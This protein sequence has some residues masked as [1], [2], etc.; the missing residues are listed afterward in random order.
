MTAK[1]NPEKLINELNLNK[2]DVFKYL[3]TNTIKSFREKYN[4]TF[5]K[6][7]CIT[8]FWGGYKTPKDKRK[9]IAVEN[10]KKSSDT[11]EKLLKSKLNGS[12]GYELLDNVLKRIDYDEFLKDYN[13]PMSKKQLAI[14]Y[15]CTNKM[16]DKIIDY[17]NLSVTYENFCLLS[18]NRHE[19]YK[20][21]QIEKYKATMIS[22]YGV[23]NYFKTD[24]FKNNLKLKNIEKYGVEYYPQSEDFRKKFH[25]KFKSYYCDGEH[26][27]SSWELMLWIYA[28]DHNQKIKREPIQLK[29]DCDGVQHVYFPDF[30][31]ENNLIEIKGS[32][33]LDENKRLKAVYGYDNQ[34]L[35][36]C[37]QKCIDD[38][39]VIIMTGDDLKFVFDYFNNSNYDI[40]E[41][42]TKNED[43]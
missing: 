23:D 4:L 37:K 10:G 40:E 18:K 24:I 41:F 19:G 3:E 27:D 39:G 1:L 5:N 11:P 43:E 35:L 38:N 21:R 42:K 2:E 32:H 28:R 7:K 17:F 30:L 31:Y 16:I 8:D 14:K 20:E 6:F 26:F 33:M 12:H 9:A 13:L 22:I 15:K 34:R 25:P 29:Y 36:D